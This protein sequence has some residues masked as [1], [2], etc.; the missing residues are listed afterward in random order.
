M[1]CFN[2]GSNNDLR[3]HLLKQDHEEVEDA[4]GFVFVC[5]K[6]YRKNKYFDLHWEIR[7]DTEEGQSQE[8]H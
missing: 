8:T 4:I 5:L 2:C 7:N 6:C 1:K 3:M